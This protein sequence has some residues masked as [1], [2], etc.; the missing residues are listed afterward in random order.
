MTAL[1]RLGVCLMAL[2]PCLAHAGMDRTALVQ[3]APSV[4]KVEAVSAG[5][6][7]QLGSGVIVGAGRV[8]TNCHVTRKAQNVFVVKQGIRWPATLQA[9]DV[10]R[11]LCVLRVPSVEGD[12]VPIAH[13]VTLKV[14]QPVMA[15]GYTGGA[16]MQLSEGAVVA[17]H[18]WQD[19]KMIQ[20]SNW[21]SS[22]ASGGGLFNAEGALVGILT[23]RLRG[24]AAHYFA[25]PADWLI[26]GLD[27]ESRYTAIGPLE[28]ETFWEQGPQA[29]PLFLQ[30]AAMEQRQQWDALA[31]LAER[32]SEAAADEA[33]PAFLLGIAY[34]GLGR[35]E[36][37]IDALRRSLR[38]DPG[39]SRS[40]A[41]L[42][43]IYKRQGRAG[44]VRTALGSLAV[45]DPEQARELSNE[46]EKP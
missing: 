18:R 1:R 26:Q 46:L 22:G 37:S 33:E 8:V 5:G 40:W 6:R 16:M 2:A 34:D 15:I 4:L 36:A 11:D 10:M 7:L 39:Y 14:G 35:T 23:F 12:I 38:V 9:A 3:V 41:R 29:Q 21:F 17:L 42:A 31:R 20:S 13:A 44:D 43:Q 27:D 24:G 28:G 45:L 19:S 30:A 32:W 25:A